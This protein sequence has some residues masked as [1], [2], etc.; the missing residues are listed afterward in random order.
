MIPIGK[1]VN[2]KMIV[3]IVG[4]K[5]QMHPHNAKQSYNYLSPY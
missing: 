2:S 5:H 4:N 1:M 3:R